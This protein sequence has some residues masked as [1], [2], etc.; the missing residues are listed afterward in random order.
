MD[1]RNYLG[2]G[3]FDLLPT[4]LVDTALLETASDDW[5]GDFNGDAVPDLVTVNNNSAALMVLLGRGDGTFDS[6]KI[7]LPRD[8]YWGVAAGDLDGDGLDDIIAVDAR[9]HEAAHITVFIAER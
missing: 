7:D 4:K 5:F 2:L 1:P 9:A 8:G 6:R 3:D